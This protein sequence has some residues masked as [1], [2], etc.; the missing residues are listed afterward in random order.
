M[1]VRSFFAADDGH[2]V[3]TT[4]KRYHD[5]HAILVSRGIVGPSVRSG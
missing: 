1:S 5:N 2:F 4:H 3:F